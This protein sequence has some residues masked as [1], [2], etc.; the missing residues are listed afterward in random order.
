M[1]KILQSTIHRYAENRE[2]DYVSAKVLGEQ[3][4]LTFRNENDLLE[5]KK[6]IDRYLKTFNESDWQ[7][8]ENYLA[9]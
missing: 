9:D 5:W 1:D 3:Y 7:G 4:G 2:I 8:I 6:V